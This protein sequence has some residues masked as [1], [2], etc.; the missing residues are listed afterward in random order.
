M[1]AHAGALGFTVGQR[2][3]L[4]LRRPAADGRPRYVV[5]VRPQEATVVVGPAEALV[6]HRLA[7]SHVRLPGGRAPRAGDHVGVQVRAHGEELPG[8]VESVEATGGGDEGSLAVRLRRPARGVALGQTMVLYDG[9][10]VVASATID[11][12]G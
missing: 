1:G 7:G 6:V 11:A 10:R 2:K 9:T 8:V 3:G 4:A 5:A 12:T